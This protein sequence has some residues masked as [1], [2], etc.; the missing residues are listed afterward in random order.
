MFTF[1]SIRLYY[2]IGLFSLLPQTPWP[3]FLFDHK[4]PDPVFS[5]STNTLTLFSL[6]A[7]TPLDPVFCDTLLTCLATQ[8]LLSPSCNHNII[9]HQIL[10]EK[11]LL[12]CLTSL[13]LYQFLCQQIFSDHG[14]GFE[15]YGCGEMYFVRNLTMSTIS[16][17]NNP[18]WGFSMGMKVKHFIYFFVL[19][20]W[21]FGK[22]LEK[23][24]IKFRLSNLIPKG[25]GGVVFWKLIE[26]KIKSLYL[27]NATKEETIEQIVL[28]EKGAAEK[29]HS[30]S[31]AIFFL[32][33]VIVLC[34]FLVHLLLQT[35]FH[36]IPESLAIGRYSFIHSFILSFNHSCF[37]SSF[38]SFLLLFIYSFIH[39]FIY[40]FIH[41][42]FV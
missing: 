36:Y 22:S 26:F 27:Q 37:H 12:F 39:L 15:I 25:R 35:K 21:I 29:E 17:S 4:H 13:K 7:Q 42:P 23:S 33:F 30:S 16:C 28:P 9:I 20:K 14:H 38:H 3:C 11:N 6:W 31:L 19:N 5:L 1:C 2:T 34:I 18:K 8:F 10:E 41:F 24:K 40:S 32:L